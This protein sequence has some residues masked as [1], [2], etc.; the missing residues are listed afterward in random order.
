M[1]IQKI[2]EDIF[3][4][5]ADV[6]TLDTKIQNRV[7]E[8]K[9]VHQQIKEI[10]DRINEQVGDLYKQIKTLEKQ[11]GIF[12]K[13]IMPELKRLEDHTIR[14]EGILIELK[15]GRRS[16]KVGYEF[17]ASKVASEL[18][19]GAEEAMAEAAKFAQAPTIEITSNKKTAGKILDFLIMK[20]RSLISWAQNLTA[21]ND[22]IGAML[23]QI[24]GAA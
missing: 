15:A 6:G 22:K 2:A 19:T 17:L 18:I 13:E 8:M 1:D 23:E 20:F 24:E 3:K 4:E 21:R 12:E 10:Q 16:P 7:K 11:S 14:A 9:K 5:S